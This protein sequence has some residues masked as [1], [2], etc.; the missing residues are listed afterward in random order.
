M[1]ASR[2]RTNEVLKNLVEAGYMSAGQ[3][4]A[5]WLNPARV[6]E[7]HQSQSPDWFLDWAFEEVQRLAEGKGHYVLT[8]RVTVDLEMQK[9]AQDALRAGLLRYHGGMGFRAPIAHIDLDP[10]KWQTQLITLNKSVSYQNWRVG[11]VVERS[12]P[13]ASI[14][15]SDGKTA[16]LTGL[17][18]A[19]RVG[20][21]IAAAPL[22][23][24][25]YAVKSIPEVSG[26]MLVESPSDGRIVAMQGG[27]DAGLASFNRATQETIF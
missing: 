1:P 10:D 22:G 16:A 2:A 11:V 23:N 7:P 20:D 6:I 21:V 17:P 15:F 13:S 5:A 8:A 25:V 18:D 14:G 27:F 3:V 26:G 9:A 12:G 19:L 4:H 24:G